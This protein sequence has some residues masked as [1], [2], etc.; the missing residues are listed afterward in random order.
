[1]N[2]PMDSRAPN[3]RGV[4]S[5][6]LAC[7]RGSGYIFFPVMDGVSLAIA[8]VPKQPFRDRGNACYRQQRMIAW[9]ISPR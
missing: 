9:F 7:Q 6:S 1:M 2:S 5:L 8:S 3:Q 4:R